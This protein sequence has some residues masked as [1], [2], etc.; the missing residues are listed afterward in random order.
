M[1]INLYL[2]IKVVLLTPL[3]ERYDPSHS[4]DWQEVTEMFT[5]RSNF[6]T[7]V[8]D[9]MIFVIGGFNGKVFSLSCKHRSY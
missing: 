9:D 3:G 2:V 7:A 8:L 5:P 6:A 1:L 4:E